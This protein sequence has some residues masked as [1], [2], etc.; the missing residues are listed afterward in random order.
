MMYQAKK[1]SVITALVLLTIWPMAHHVIVRALDLNPWKWFGWS[2][3]TV[4]PQRVRAFAFS[5][6]DQRRLLP[7]RLPR[8]DAQ[9]LMQAYNDFSLLRLEFGPRVEPDGFARALLVA[10]PEVN[11]VSIYIQRLGVDRASATVVEQSLTDPPYTYRRD[12]LFE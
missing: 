10:F 4:P 11:G 12:D 9:R 1:R 2:M 5:L 8:R 3:Y 6:D 7:T